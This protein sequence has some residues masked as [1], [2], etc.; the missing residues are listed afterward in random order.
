MLFRFH[1]SALKQKDANR[2]RRE[3]Q[4]QKTFKCNCKILQVGKR[5]MRTT[6]P[7]STQFNSTSSTVNFSQRQSH[8]SAQ[9]YHSLPKSTTVLEQ[10]SKF[11][12]LRGFSFLRCLSFLL[13]VLLTHCATSESSRIGSTV[14]I[15]LAVSNLPGTAVEITHSCHGYSISL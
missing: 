12:L 4:R 10:L 5:I 8:R 13:E 9:V 2:I 7:N 15:H 3:L 1:P 14:P 11:V 6:I